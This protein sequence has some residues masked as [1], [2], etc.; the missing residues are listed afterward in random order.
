MPLSLNNNRGSVSSGRMKI[1]VP[2]RQCLI[3][4]K[5]ERL[6]VIIPHFIKPPGTNKRVT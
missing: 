4:N 3:E 6:H 2:G 1:E 5:W